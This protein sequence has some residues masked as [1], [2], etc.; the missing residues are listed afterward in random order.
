M[1][2]MV[3]GGGGGRGILDRAWAEGLEVSNVNSSQKSESIRVLLEL[4]I[5][6][7]KIIFP[8]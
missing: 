4:L 3:G 5:I 6:L 8:F 2:V 1:P 7:A